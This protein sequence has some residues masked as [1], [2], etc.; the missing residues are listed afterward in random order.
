[1]AQS[2]ITSLSLVSSRMGISAHPTSSLPWEQT[3]KINEMKAV[4]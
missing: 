3:D 1:L 2:K 4:V